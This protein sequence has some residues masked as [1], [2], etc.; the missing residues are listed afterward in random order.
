MNSLLPLKGP[1]SYKTFFF[2]VWFAAETYYIYLQICWYIAKLRYIIVIAL[3]KT[4]IMFFIT[5]LIFL[6]SR[7]IINIFKNVLISTGHF[8]GIM[9]KILFQFI[10]SILIFLN[11]WKELKY[12]FILWNLKELYWRSY[13]FRMEKEV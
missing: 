9:T 13:C 4:K 6:K 11:Y 8:F 5:K 12:K 1:F 10:Y 3:L 7:K 2:S